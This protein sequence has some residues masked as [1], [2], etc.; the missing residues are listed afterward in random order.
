[1][2]HV[3]GFG[4]L[5]GTLNQQQANHLFNSPPPN[6]GHQQARTN[7]Q[8]PQ[9]Q[10]AAM[11]HF[12]EKYEDFIADT[13]MLRR[14]FTPDG[15]GGSQRAGA[16]GC[17]SFRTWWREAGALPV[18][19]SSLRVIGRAHTARWNT[20]LSSPLQWFT[21]GCG[22]LWG[23]V[24]LEPHHIKWRLCS[25][26]ILYVNRRWEPGAPERPPAGAGVPSECAEDL[27]GDPLAERPEP[28]C[29]QGGASS[30]KVLHCHSLHVEGLTDVGGSH[31]LSLTHTHRQAMM[32]NIWCVEIAPDQLH[33]HIR[34]PHNIP[35]MHSHRAYLYTVHTGDG[36]QHSLRRDCCGSTA[37]VQ[38]GPGVAG[39]WQFDLRLCLRSWLVELVGCRGVSSMCDAPMHLVAWHLSRRGRC[40]AA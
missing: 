23:V 25:V 26:G 20:A 34:M 17:Y 27:G 15:E 35:Y 10:Y 5:P 31:S 33:A 40:V 9:V 16:Q 28:A 29:A 6:Y 24:P 30:F 7:R 21:R 18:L 12:E 3:A 2:P 38:R 37:H 14:R 32:A 36:G 1:M 13:V 8:P 19:R 22:R 11:S 4:A 39:V